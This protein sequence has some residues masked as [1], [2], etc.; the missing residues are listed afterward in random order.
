[1]HT[2]LC[3]HTVFYKK[4]SK[5]K[6]RLLTALQNT[7]IAIQQKDICVPLMHWGHVQENLLGQDPPS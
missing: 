3:M 2:P 5:K 6:Q 4:Q 1:M 7:D